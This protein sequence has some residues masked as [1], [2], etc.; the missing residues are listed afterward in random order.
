MNGHLA[1]FGIL[2][3]QLMH[4]FPYALMTAPLRAQDTA[5]LGGSPVWGI[6]PADPM[7]TT[8]R[9]IQSPQGDRIMAR[10]R[11][12][13]DPLMEV[14]QRRIATARVPPVFRCL[15]YSRCN[16]GGAIAFALAATLRPLCAKLATGY[17]RRVV[18]TGWYDAGHVVGD[19]GG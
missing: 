14:D 10:N 6:T 9:R 3:K 16:I 5:R 1:S 2:E 12:T 8:I 15:D 18:K 7:G 17:T 19:V 11:F 13:Y 4:V